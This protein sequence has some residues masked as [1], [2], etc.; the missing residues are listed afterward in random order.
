MRHLLAAAALA[1]PALAQADVFPLGDRQGASFSQLVYDLP[2]GPTVSAWG[3]VTVDPVQLA[4]VTGEAAGFV[5]VRTAEGWVALNL[6]VQTEPWREYPRDL[7]GE[8]G[9]D[10]VLPVSFDFSLGAERAR[11]QLDATVVFSDA[12]LLGKADLASLDTLPATPFAVRQVREDLPR[13]VGT[14]YAPLPP[15]GLPPPPENPQIALPEPLQGYWARMTPHPVNIESA[16]NQCASVAIANMLEYMRLTFGSTRGFTT[17][18]FAHIKGLLGDTSLVGIMDSFNRRQVTDTCIGNGTDYCVDSPIQTGLFEGALRFLSMSND[19]NRLHVRYQGDFG[20]SCAQETD[21]HVVDDGSE[22]TFDWICDRI[23]AGDGVVLTYHRFKVDV[24]A[25][26]GQPIYPGMFEV[27][28]G[29]HAIRVHGCGMMAGRPFLRVLNDTQQ[30]G[31]IDD[32]CEERPGLA[33]QLV[34]VEDVD[35]DGVL[36]YGDSALKELAFAFAVSIDP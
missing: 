34:Y 26:Q 9:V 31:M 14:D 28:T 18:G 11:R 35:G 23:Q 25:A 5:S 8:G 32:V 4:R 1:L 19:V 33:S 10:D 12:P 30:D 24:E 16:R 15:D 20:D 17:A 6:P 36:N 27:I 29:A 3:R 21:V 22:V 7:Q 2:D 13:G